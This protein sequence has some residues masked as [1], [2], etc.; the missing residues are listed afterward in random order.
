MSTL[1]AIQKTIAAQKE[2]DSVKLSPN[3]ADTSLTAS[4]EEGV[5]IEASNATVKNAGEAGSITIKGGEPHRASIDGGGITIQGGHQP[6][7]TSAHKAGDVNLFSG[8]GYKGGDV[9]ITTGDNL[10]TSAN[11]SSPKGGDLYLLTGGG[12]KKKDAFPT[13]YRSIIATGAIGIETGAVQSDSIASGNVRVATGKPHTHTDSTSGDI[14]IESGG[15]SATTDA[16]KS[17]FIKIRTGQGGTNQSGVL[18]ISTGNTS[19]VNSGEINLYSG[20]CT[21]GVSGDVSLKSGN[22][23]S[24]SSGS[25]TLSTGTGQSGTGNLIVES[26]STNTGLSGLLTL[27]SGGSTL[28]GS[29]NVSLSSGLSPIGTSGQVQVYSGSSASGDSGVVNLYSGDSTTGNSGAVSLKSGDGGSGLSDN[30]GGITLQTGDSGSQTGTILIKAG[31][32]SSGSNG[33]VQLVTS[34]VTNVSS[35]NSGGLWFQTGSHVGQSDTGSATFKTGSNTGTGLSG[36]MDI[37]TGDADGDSTGALEIKTGFTP[38]DGF[39]SG[40]ITIA[41]GGKEDG[42]GNPTDAT[43]SDEAQSGSMTIRTGNTRV[44]SG[45]IKATTGAV[46]GGSSTS[47]DIELDTGNSNGG[48]GYTYIRTG[49]AVASSSGELYLST[50]N[51][52]VGT[53]AIS[54][55][56]GNNSGDSGNTGAI[57]I[58]TGDMTTG[59][60][61]ITSGNIVIK[62]GR[63][64]GDGDTGSITIETGINDNGSNGDGQGND[65]GDIAIKSGVVNSSV[66]NKR[67]GDVFIMSGDAESGAGCG[68]VHL[69]TG[70]PTDPVG[71]ANGVW[72]MP[73]ESRFSTT[74]MVNAA[75]YNAPDL[76]LYGGD[77]KLEQNSAPSANTINGGDVNIVAGHVVRGTTGFSGDDYLSGSSG[78]QTQGEV[79]IQSNSVPYQASG[80]DSRILTTQ[81]NGVLKAMGPSPYIYGYGTIKLSVSSGEVSFV[82]LF[83]KNT[84]INDAQ[85][86]EID[87]DISSG[88]SNY[89]THE[90][91]YYGINPWK[92]ATTL[93]DEITPTNLS[94]IASFTVSDSVAQINFGHF[95]DQTLNVDIK[96]TNTDGSVSDPYL[97][98]EFT[99]NTSYGLVFNSSAVLYIH[100]ELKHRT[101]S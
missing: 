46:V 43:V 54:L 55:I 11:S 62:T 79:K 26:G 40:D 9:W 72:V 31:E 92:D 34:N 27:R 80:F 93:L 84:T 44:D 100:Y 33:H 87:M 88:T 12:E 13:E 38:A 3:S 2:G 69:K 76:Y 47:G 91:Q 60:D 85:S 73:G 35:G 10:D 4:R 30:S 51:G 71:V 57:T 53:G 66:N 83:F 42:S 39:T 19:V 23:T 21:T 56:T 20:D 8:D 48:S 86:Q 1:T 68:V 97:T 36:K 41:T 90:E 58:Q 64:H 22:T 74:N 5:L 18:E 28:G 14:T 77:V 63:N 59:F 99:D 17:G 32:S 75:S 95:N 67:S 81:A 6:I 50:G 65:S 98:L 37:Y 52:E 101:Y 25:T 61:T 78:T 70:I 96:T 45:N 7:T 15:T 49:T 16:G 89:P 94:L 29:G 82:P 24:Q